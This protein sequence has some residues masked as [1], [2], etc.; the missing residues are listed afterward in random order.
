MGA[1]KGR[2]TETAINLLTAQIRTTLK[3]KGVASVLSMDM[4]GAF[5]HVV[6]E[7]LIDILKLKRVPEFLVGWTSSFMSDRTTTLCFDNRESPPRD[8][9]AGIPQ[10]SPISPILFLFY[11]SE[12]IDLC[13]QHDLN[14][15]R[16]G[17]VDD[18]NVIAWSR[19]PLHNVKILRNVHDKCT[20]WARRHG[21]KFAPDK[22]ELIHVSRRRKINRNV[23]I[24]LGE[25]YWALQVLVRLTSHGRVLAVMPHQRNGG[26]RAV[27]WGQ[28]FYSQEMSW[29]GKC[30]EVGMVLSL[31]ILRLQS[32]FVSKTGIC[33]CM[34]FQESRRLRLP[35][36]RTP[37]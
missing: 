10:G 2:S 6:R 33:S 24:R 22:Y 28:V 37:V 1:R 36:V 9:A 11:N 32:F 30:V 3:G 12:L 8:I 34:R 13:N 14:A 29:L 16:I 23:G 25:T 5:D 31:S 17:F 19:S 21:A 4:S 27:S 26:Y 20:D 7:R 15:R 35:G 18:V